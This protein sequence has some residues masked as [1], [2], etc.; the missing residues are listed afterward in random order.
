[1]KDTAEGCCNAESRQACNGS[2]C[3][4]TTKQNV[5]LFFCQTRMNVVDECMN[6][7]QAEHSKCLGHIYTRKVKLKQYTESRRI[8]H[9]THFQCQIL[10]CIKQSD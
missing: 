9:L 7:T 10:Y 8:K 6:L 2:Y 4:Q 5:K 1:M 3:D